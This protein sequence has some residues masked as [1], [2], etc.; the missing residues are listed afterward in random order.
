[1]PLIRSSV[2]AALILF[3]INPTARAQALTALQTCISHNIDNNTLRL[4]YSQLVDRKGKVS[5]S[6]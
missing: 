5:G 2:V 1:M 3:Q 6:A 4:T